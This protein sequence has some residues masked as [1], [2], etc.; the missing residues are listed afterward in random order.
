[1][2]LL[3][4]ISVLLFSGCGFTTEESNLTRAKCEAACKNHGGFYKLLGAREFRFKGDDGAI[5]KDGS[6][7]SFKN[8]TG[9][10]VAE[11]LNKIEKSNQ[12]PKF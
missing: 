11:A 8:L 7:V 2:R 1:M 5:C 10:D 9:P 3:I 6:E 12:L 4:F